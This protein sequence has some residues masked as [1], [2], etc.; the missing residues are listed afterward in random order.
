MKVNLIYLRVTYRLLHRVWERCDTSGAVGTVEQR[1]V[2]KEA[3]TLA[4]SFS[5]NN[6]GR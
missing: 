1:L 2:T 4:I 5:G 6:L 3:R